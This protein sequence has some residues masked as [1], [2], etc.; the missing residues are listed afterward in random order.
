[1]AGAAPTAGR[2]AWRPGGAAEAGVVLTSPAEIVLGWRC[3]APAGGAPAPAAATPPAPGAPPGVTPLPARPAE[4]SDEWISA[5]RREHRRLARPPWRQAVLASLVV[6]GATAAG[7]S[8][9][10]AVPLAVALAAAGCGLAARAG[11]QLRRDRLALLCAVAAEQERVTRFSAVQAE[12]A[13][14]RAGARAR[15]LGDWRLRQQAGPARWQPVTIPGRVHR[16]D[17]AGGTLAGWSALLTT[18]AVP[19]LARGGRVRVLDLTEG[20][21]AAD[22]IALARRCGLDP[23]VQ[24]L[25]ADLPAVGLPAGGPDSARL[26][27]L[28]A[29]T[30]AAADGPE[31]T[32]APADPARDAALLGRVLVAL[33][34]DISLPRLLAGL[35][36][37]GQIGGP[38]D[39]LEAAGLST[40]QLTRLGE[41]AGREAGRLVVE[42]AW[43]LEARLRVLA[44]LGTAPRP[45][46]AADP[47]Q[48]T[49]LDRRASAVGNRVLAAFAVEALTAVLRQSPQQPRWHELT[50]VLGSERL[51]AS[52]LDR[53]TDAAECCGAG[54]VL[55]YRSLPAHVRERLGRGDA[56]LGFMRLGNADDARAAAEQIGT[57]HRFVISQLT[58]SVS[59]SVTDTTGDSYTSTTG[60]ADS[61]ARSQSLSLTAGRT[62]GRSRPG[63]LAPLSG[64]AGTSRDASSSTAFSDSVSVTAGINAG[65]SW[66]WSTSAAIGTSDSIAATAQRSRE[67]LVEQ[68]ELQQ[69]PHSAVLV[70]YAGPDGRQVALADANPAIMAL[71]A[72][73]PPP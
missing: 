9:A 58:D 40:A 52:A 31:Q 19:Q 36:V 73:P 4:V 34:D 38:A 14:A 54:L 47:V 20:G 12:H 37:A 27:E 65:T 64:G 60:T 8:G 53:L 42:R 63:A 6:C 35:R 10:A 44:P 62:R 11:R 70:C 57:G 5:Q 66:G 50:C 69:L 17:V 72:G 29:L 68:H 21:V 48:V 61:V 7:V 67:F 25:P 55:G 45:A 49:W 51:P 71:P 1:M 13:R 32:G 24:V 46:A 56:A 3:D 33:G 2:L 43:A 30:V 59:C 28:L 26:A 41:L 39:Q 15:R 22:L 16:L 23:L 18:L